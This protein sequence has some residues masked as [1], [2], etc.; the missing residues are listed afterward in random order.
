MS[1]LSPYEQNI[2][3]FVYVLEQQPNLLTPEDRLSLEELLT[4]SP[5]DVEQIS[6]DIT[7]WYEN[8]PDI[9]AAIFELPIN[10]LS[11]GP[12]GRQAKI[13]PREAKEL[14]ENA[15]RRSKPPTK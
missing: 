8:H 12:G 6:N 15:V 11:R 7:I 13:T 10:F 1:E 5:D 14:I 3:D 4:I 9:E 2:L